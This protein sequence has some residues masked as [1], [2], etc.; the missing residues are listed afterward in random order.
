MAIYKSL[1]SANF[2]TG[3]CTFQ[4]MDGSQ[5][6][7]VIPEVTARGVALWADGENI[8]KALPMLTNEQ[9]EWFITG[10]E[11][12]DWDRVFGDEEE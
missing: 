11:Q 12:S 8:Q 5:F 4:K 3:T 1:V 6:S 7:K 2:N 10:M 9:R